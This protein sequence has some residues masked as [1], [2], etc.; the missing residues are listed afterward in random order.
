VKLTNRIKQSILLL[1]ILSVTYY[2][3]AQTTLSQELQAE[4]AVE[5]LKDK[6]IAEDEVKKALKKKG[7]DLDNLK[8]E[9]LATLE[10]DIKLVVSELESEKG[11]TA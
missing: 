4:R 5:E 3:D 7:I 2:A 8:P 9:Q 1:C 11:D 10:E 6:G